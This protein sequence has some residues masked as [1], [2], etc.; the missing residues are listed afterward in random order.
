MMVPMSLLGCD[1]AGSDES[2]VDLSSPELLAR[3]VHACVLA[4]DFDAFRRACLTADQLGELRQ[5]ARSDR[6]AE[7][8]EERIAEMTAD[9]QA[10]DASLRRYF[11]KVVREIHTAGG[12]DVMYISATP[13]PERAVNP[14]VK[15][16]STLGVHFSS[17]VMLRIDSPVKVGEQWVIADDGPVGVQKSTDN[18]LDRK[19]VEGFSAGSLAINSPEGIEPSAD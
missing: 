16:L 7:R 15:G 19:I 8:I 11:E 3:H 17:G 4:N 2:G 5:F 1:Q 13:K 6:E 12:F 9:A 10:Y 18:F 14:K